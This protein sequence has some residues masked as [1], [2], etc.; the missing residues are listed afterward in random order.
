MGFVYVEA[1]KKRKRVVYILVELRSVFFAHCGQLSLSAD[2]ACKLGNLY[3]KEAR[4]DMTD[5]G[6]GFPQT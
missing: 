5:M 1:K 6:G 2:E 3:N 4:R